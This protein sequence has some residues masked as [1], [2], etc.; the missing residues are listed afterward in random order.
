MVMGVSGGLAVGRAAAMPMAGL[1]I[2]AL[3]PVALPVTG[4]REVELAP[5][6]RSRADAAE[7]PG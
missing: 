2:A 7:L 3:N 4:A 1:G 5:G 6:H